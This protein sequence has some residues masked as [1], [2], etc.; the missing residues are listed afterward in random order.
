V[1]KIVAEN[2]YTDN[3]DKNSAEQF[4]R[5]LEWRSINETRIR[6]MKV[7]VFKWTRV[8][9]SGDSLQIVPLRIIS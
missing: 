1:F 9:R 6:A 8:S 2:G 4:L 5:M 7:S 3:S